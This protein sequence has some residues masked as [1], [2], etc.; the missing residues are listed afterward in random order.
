MALTIA[1]PG[2]GRR[3]QLPEQ[4]H[5]E[6]VKCPWCQLTFPAAQARPAAPI[7]SAAARSPAPDQIPTLER[8]EDG[9]DDRRR[10]A[11]PRMRP[12]PP[13]PKKG[14]GWT[15]LLVVG[16]VL[17]GGGVLAGGVAVIG[18]FGARPPVTTYPPRPS[19]PAPNGTGFPALGRPQPQSDKELNKDLVV[20]FANLGAAFRQGNGEGIV[21][22]FDLERMLQE[23]AAQSAMPVNS[24][25]VRTARPTFAA[26]LQR[27]AG[28]M[29]WTDTEIREVKRLNETEVVVTARHTEPDQTT[30][31]F[32]W[33]LTRRNGAW[34]VYDLEAAAVALRMSIMVAA[35]TNE[36]PGLADQQGL[37]KAIKVLTE[38]M[39]LAGAGGNP[40]AAEQKLQ[41]IDGV[42]LP[43][44][45][46]ALRLLVVGMIRL[47]EG[48]PK[49]AVVAL[50]KALTLHPDLPLVD[51]LKGIAYN[52]LGQY[53]KAQK[54]LETY[55]NLMGDDADICFQLG[56][57]VRNQKR[58]PEAAVLY[59]KSLDLQPQQGEV[60]RSLLRCLSGA[61][62][63]TDLG[64]RF[65]KL[66]EHRAHFTFVPRTA[67]ARFRSL[68][69]L[70]DPDV[71][72]LDPVCAP[73][74]YYV[75]WCSAQLQHAAGQRRNP[76]RLLWT[77]RPTSTSAPTT[78]RAS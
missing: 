31:V 15:T 42:T 17:V 19:F 25:D 23:F 11:R 43:R 71:H 41:Q 48:Q 30:K 54:H 73:A 27:D 67:A 64:P 18:S 56:E 45:L 21:A 16:L 34:K 37:R 22:Y 29:H 6:T 63:N 62:D 7:G 36:T 5:S 68:E 35:V 32:R 72:R 77:S 51:L 40:R 65:A 20:L 8:W 12:L 61:E 4:F 74:A 44:P 39:K 75:A 9:A 52:R 28:A 57:S 78:L 76:S 47:S 53:D 13:P 70:A 59:R 1:C 58:F 26:T 24:N 69:P 33:W 55:H 3:L 2:C 60:F 50:N 66:T 49:E 38:A 10:P 14:S 46:E